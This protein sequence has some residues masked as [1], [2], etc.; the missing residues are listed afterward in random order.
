MTS[1]GVEAL[2]FGEFC[3]SG[4]GFALALEGAGLGA[5]EAGGFGAGPGLGLAD[6]VGDVNLGCGG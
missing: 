1:D 6:L 4:F 5:E 3:V 2:G